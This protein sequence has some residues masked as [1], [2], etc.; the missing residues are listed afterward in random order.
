MAAPASATCAGEDDSSGVPPGKRPELAGDLGQ[1]DR[2]YELS[3]L[4]A[5]VERFLSSTADAAFDAQEA[6]LV[7]DLGRRLCARVAGPRDE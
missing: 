5:Q 4:T 3:R 7:A 2:R 1:P 6:A